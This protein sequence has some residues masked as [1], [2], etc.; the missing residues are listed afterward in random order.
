M[1]RR[2]I[3]P[4]LEG[5]PFGVVYADPPWSY[6]DKARAGRRGVEFKYGTM[7]T[8]EIAALDVPSVVDRDA[9][10]FLWAVPPMLDDARLVMK[11]WGF[12]YV[13]FGFVWVKLSSETGLLHWGMGNWTR[14]NA[15]PVLLGVRGE[16]GRA[17]R[18]VHQIVVAPV[19]P[20]LHSRKPAEVRRR[21]EMVA[22]NT[23]RLELFATERSPGWTSVGF[24]ADG[25]DVRDVLGVR[26]FIP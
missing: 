15:E 3:R 5:S 22:D 19:D 10:L 21:V 24:S 16:P 18:G 2:I 7:A 17:S 8:G 25:R 4:A 11:A 23:R 14:A 9:M 1:T 13:T 12:R 20:I 26:P 6:R